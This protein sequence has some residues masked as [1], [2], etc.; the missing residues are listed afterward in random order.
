MPQGP[1]LHGNLTAPYKPKE[2]QKG[3]SWMIPMIELT[4]ITTLEDIQL[5]YETARPKNNKRWITVYGILAALCFGLFRF[6][7]R[8]TFLLIYGTF[9]VGY[10]VWLWFWPR[11][12][13]KKQYERYMKDY[14]GEIPPCQMFFGEHIS[15]V[16]VEGETII[17]YEKIDQIVLKKGRLILKR[18]NEIGWYLVKMDTFIR[19]D[20]DVLFRLLGEKC[21][22]AEF[23]GFP[24]S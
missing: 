20:Q 23:V 13:A 1:S 15:L 3:D 9:C 17:P 22:N 11:R 24:K 8:G 12:A 2:N 19:G 5:L 7:E 4:T 6:S 10:G 18:R 21:T 16:D 14:D